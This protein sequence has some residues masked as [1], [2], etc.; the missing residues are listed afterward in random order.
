M[1]KKINLGRLRSAGVDA[2]WKVPLYL[3]TEHLDCRLPVLNFSQLAPSERPILVS[4]TL[5]GEPQMEWRNGSP[6][7]KWALSDPHGEVLRFSFFGDARPTIERLRKQPGP[8]WL[9]GQIQCY[10]ATPFLVR[11][12]VADPT[13]SGRIVPIY[14]GKAGKLSAQN[15]RRLMSK[16]LPQTI[17]L[18]ASRLREQLTSFVEPYRIRALLQCSRWTLEELLHHVHFPNSP[19]EAAQALWVMDRMAALISACE[20]KKAAQNKLPERR[21][22]FRTQGWEDLAAA[23][24]HPLTDEQ[25]TGIH[26]LVEKLK[27]PRASQTLI[28]GDV[29]TGKTITYQVPVAYAVKAGARAAVLLPHGRLALQAYREFHSLWPDLPIR[30]VSGEDGGEEDLSDCPLLVG[31]TALLHRPVGRFDLVVVDEQQRFSVEQRNML[32]NGGA[33]LIE[34]SATPI[35]RSMALAVYGALDVIPITQRHS[36]QNIHNSI[37]LPNQVR[38]MLEKVR[39]LIDNG[40]RILVVCPKRQ[41][42]D[43]D[44]LSSVRRV[45]DR[46]ETLFP[47]RVRRAESEMDEKAIAQAIDDII[48]GKAQI[49]VSTTVV[50][51]G[52][53]LP[54]LRGVIVTN[55]DRFG[56]SQLHQIRGR[57]AREG[58]DGWF[59]IYLPR[60]VNDKTMARLQSVVSTCNGFELSKL[61]MKIRGTGDLSRTGRRQHGAADNLLY[62][63]PVQTE[64]L[65]EMVGLL[66]EQGS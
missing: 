50:E 41:G 1:K 32:T 15:A 25:R 10:G 5:Y 47:G 6:L 29:G 34:I 16:L 42:D 58:G 45:A 48:L 35:P 28:N 44:A 60:P 53:N 4:G 65:D 39:S 57:L 30:L 66:F 20:L 33:H 54:D 18:C 19:A 22:I 7:T 56:V 36:P 52:L 24:P 17:P 46:W 64:L 31:T 8:V 3:P 13:M 14:P 2:P 26:R 11:V 40:S 49:L 63:R 51:T 27:A 55:G 43:Q 21:P 62:N 12:E 23:F 9:T 37:V 38:L 61:D 59:W